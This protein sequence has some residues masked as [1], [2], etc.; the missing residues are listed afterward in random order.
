MAMMMVELTVADYG[1][2]RP[3][4]EKYEPLRTA[5]GVTNPRIYRNADKGNEVLLLFD[6]A[7]VSKARQV[8]VSPEVRAGMQEA[9]VIGPPKAHI[10]E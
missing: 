9:G 7:D 4:F 1:K 6:V 10:V 2:W 8:L 3:V 5:A